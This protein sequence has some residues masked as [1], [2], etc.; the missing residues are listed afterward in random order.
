MTE[1]TEP[2]V[3]PR[4]LYDEQTATH[5]D[6][7]VLHPL[8]SLLEEPEGSGSLAQIVDLLTNIVAILAQHSR[9]LD[10]IKST[11]IGAGGPSP[12]VQP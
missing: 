7:R 6:V 2:K 11:V 5:A 1:S 3:T 4:V 10:E 8:L 9:T 12:I